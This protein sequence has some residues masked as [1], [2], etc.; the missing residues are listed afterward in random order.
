MNNA[1]VGECVSCVSGSLFRS[2][3]DLVLA[4]LHP[5]ALTQGCWEQPNIYTI[6]DK[7]DPEMKP[8]MVSL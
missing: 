1:G 2:L 3:P 5:P 4:L 6:M 8:K 7:N